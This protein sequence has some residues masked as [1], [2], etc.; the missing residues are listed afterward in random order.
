[1]K[2]FIDTNLWVRFFIQD[3]QNQYEATKSLLARVEIGELKAYTS[4]IVLLELQFV[5]QRLYKLSFEGVIEIFEAIR[6]VREIVIIEKTNFDLALTFYRKY[7]IKLPDCL[8]ASQ[9]PKNVV[10]VSFDEELPKIKEITVKKPQE[11][12]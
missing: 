1:M 12:E 5:L 11:I 3:I 10:L 9:L 8:I 2:I 7:R 6:K 4:T